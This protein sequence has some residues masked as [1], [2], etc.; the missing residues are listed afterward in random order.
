MT[1]QRRWRSKK[2]E[3]NKRRAQI[4]K[5]REK[6]T[7]DVK[8]K[9]NSA[10]MLNIDS[11]SDQLEFT[12]WII[13]YCFEDEREKETKLIDNWGR[14]QITHVIRVRNNCENFHKE[15]LEQKKIERNDDQ[16]KEASTRQWRIF[17]EGFITF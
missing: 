1:Y 5:K 11:I 15:F 7:N 16:K 9:K 13:V 17:E 14:S 2:K 6:K 12:V 3:K 4:I 10:D 8:E